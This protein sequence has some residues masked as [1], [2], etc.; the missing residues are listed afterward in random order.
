M[1]TRT[2]ILNKNY[3]AICKHGFQGLRTDKVISELNITKGA[4]YHY[5]PS[6]NSVGYAVVDEI[7]TPNYVSNW[8]N[9]IREDVHV[10]DAFIEA[11]TTI[12]GYSNPENI[13]LGCPLNNLIQEMSPLDEGF[14]KRL[15]K[16]VNTKKKYMQEALQYGI[17][18]QQ[19]KADIDP[20]QTALFVLASFEGSYSIGKIFQ[21][22]KAFAD[23]FDQLI[24]FLN[25]LKA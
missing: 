16:I 4:F 25:K 21:S 10:I 2:Q 19:V 6:K 5:F 15:L 24:N 11:L 12:K 7:I 23:S 1:D 9:L 18:H 22:F 14:R 20:E 13:Y 17:E 8:A 3:E